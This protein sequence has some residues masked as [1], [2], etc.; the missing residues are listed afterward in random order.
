MSLAAPT[1][2]AASSESSEYLTDADIAEMRS[3]LKDVPDIDSKS[4]DDFANTLSKFRKQSTDE[5]TLEGVVSVF[6]H[7]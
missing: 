6:Q 5:E 2:D 3:D 4:L 7:L 1:A